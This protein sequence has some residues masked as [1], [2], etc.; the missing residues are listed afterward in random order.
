MRVGSQFPQPF[1]LSKNLV[2]PFLK[3][4]LTLP[5]LLQPCHHLF[6]CAPFVRSCCFHISHCLMIQR[7]KDTNF[8]RYCCGFR[9]E[10]ISVCGKSREYRVPC[11]TQS[12][13]W[14]WQQGGLPHPCFG[15][16]KIKDPLIRGCWCQRMLASFIVFLVDEGINA[17]LVGWYG[18]A[19]LNREIL[20]KKHGGLSPVLNR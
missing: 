5:G 14:M 13:K 8:S 17:A 6:A 3:G 15:S 9:E 7:C 19:A 2:C 4:I 1:L 12:I 18:Q 10:K 20:H 16:R 11:P